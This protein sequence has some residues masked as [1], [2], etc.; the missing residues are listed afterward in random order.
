MWYRACEI[1]VPL[2]GI[3]PGAPTFEGLSPNYWMIREVPPPLFWFFKSV[4]RQRT[5][6]C[7][8]YFNFLIIITVEHFPIC[9][10]VTHISFVVCLCASWPFSPLSS[11]YWVICLFSYWL[12]GALYLWCMSIHCLLIFCPSWYS[13]FNIVYSIF[14][15]AESFALCGGGEHSSTHTTSLPHFLSFYIMN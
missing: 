1:I 3:E 8:F 12:V 9:L 5:A 4:Y 15:T 6:C 13:S 14:T 10:C 2:P 11:L 7:I